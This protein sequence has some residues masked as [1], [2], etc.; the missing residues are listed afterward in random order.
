MGRGVLYGRTQFVHDQSSVEVRCA[1]G[2]KHNMQTYHVPVECR[3]ITGIVG[4]N[5]TME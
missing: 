2:L 5:V 1:D 4:V 3:E